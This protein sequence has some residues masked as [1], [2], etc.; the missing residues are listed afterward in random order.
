MHQHT[1]G[2]LPYVKVTVVC[3]VFGLN[4]L[5]D[6]MLFEKG[7]RII[8]CHDKIIPIEVMPIAPAINILGIPDKLNQIGYRTIPHF[9][10]V[11][12]FTLYPLS[13]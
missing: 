12:R 13:I 10:I 8:L 1:Q 11:H 4:V 3:M 5:A 6:V 2:I 7:N 9:N